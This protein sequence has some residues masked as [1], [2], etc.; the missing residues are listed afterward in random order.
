MVQIEGLDTWSDE[1]VAE[2]AFQASAAVKKEFDDNF[3]TIAL[4]YKKKHNHKYLKPAEKLWP[5]VT[6]TLIVDNTAYISTSIKGEGTYLYNPANYAAPK[7][8][9]QWVSLRAT[10]NLCRKEVV[11]ALERCQLK[12]PAKFKELNKKQL[13]EAREAAKEAA[14]KAAEEAGDAFD[15]ENWENDNPEEDVKSSGHRTG[16]SCGEP[17][18]ALAYCTTGSGKK[19][20]E[21]NA[22]V[23]SVD[24]TYG[25][26][27]RYAPPCGGWEKKNTVSTFLE[28]LKL[29]VSMR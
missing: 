4:D 15:E 26:S 14:K 7:G 21:A 11:Q 3:D 10:N 12:S 9:P 27:P 16:A 29:D 25:K 18:A 28:E 22:R 13:L 20:A 6:S 2:L 1:Q 17:M 8:D 5:T 23:M 24:Y 19:I